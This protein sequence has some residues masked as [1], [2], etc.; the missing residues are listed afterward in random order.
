[1]NYWPGL[2]AAGPRV[3]FAGNGGKGIKNGT[4]NMLKNSIFVIKK[5]HEN[6]DHERLNILLHREFFMY[7]V[8][9]DRKGAY[10][11]CSFIVSGRA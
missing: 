7:R 8:L 3:S 6:V 1:M 4:E 10:T 5:N 2:S 9:T 11:M